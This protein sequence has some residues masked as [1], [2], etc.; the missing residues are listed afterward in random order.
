M[1][2]MP[3]MQFEGWP[4]IARLNRTIIVTEKL[5]GTNAAVV[6]VP[7]QEAEDHF[8]KLVGYAPPTVGEAQPFFAVTEHFAVAAQSRTRFIVPGKDNHGFAA[9]VQQN[10]EELSKLGPGRHF[11]EWW[12]KGIQRGYGVEGKQFSL[13]NTG[14]WS[15]EERPA[16]VSLVPVLYEGPFSFHAVAASF[17]TLRTGGSVA[18][19]GFMNPEGIVMYHT[20]AKAMFK[21][22][23]ENDTNGKGQPNAE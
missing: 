13:F 3:L 10:A 4:S 14:R 1:G 21:W 8:R 17:E 16:C 23:F 5:D 20:A 2:T 11:G 15:R 9:W 12:G 18:A 22:T 19:K 7:R 6:I